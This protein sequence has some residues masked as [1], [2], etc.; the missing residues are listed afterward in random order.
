MPDI[1]F[2]LGT[3]RVAG[4]PWNTLVGVDWVETNSGADGVRTSTPG[5]HIVRLVW[6]RVAY[7]GIYPDTVGL[8]RTLE[9]LAQ[10]G[11]AEAS[12]APIVGA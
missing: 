2:S 5:T 1:S 11:V 7:V 10:A 4:P 8:Q 9:R 3:I 6:G 12:A